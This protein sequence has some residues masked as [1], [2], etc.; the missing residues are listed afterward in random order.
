MFILFYIKYIFVKFYLF[1]LIIFL[2]G[3]IN[4]MAPG[5]PCG[6]TSSGECMNFK[7]YFCLNGEIIKNAKLC[8]CG[9]NQIISGDDCIFVCEDNTLFNE[10]SEKEISYICTNAGLKY[11]P[12]KCGC[13]EHMFFNGTDCDYKTCEDNTKYNECSLS[14]PLFC[15]NGNLI[16]NSNVCG[17]PSNYIKE[18]N[19]CVPVCEDNT[20][21]NECSL[22]KPLF[23]SDG[24]LITK[25]SVCGC[26]EHYTNVND[27]CVLIYEM[28]SKQNTFSY[29]Y[30][31]KT[32][33]ISLVVYKGLNDYLSEQPRVIWYT[34]GESPPTQK[35]FTLKNIDDEIQKPYLDEL[36]NKIKQKNT[37]ENEQALIAIR[38][39][40]NIPYDYTGLYSDTLNS[41][42]AYEVLYSN[43]GVCGEKSELLAYLLRE[44]GFGVVLF[45]FNVENHMAVGIKCYDYDYYDSGYCFIESTAPY[46]VTYSS[47]EYAG[48]GLLT[49]TPEII[50]IS[51][52]RSFDAGEEY[53]D[54]VKYEEINQMGPVLSMRYYNEWLDLVDKYGL[55]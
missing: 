10:C 17:C 49:S 44:L 32:D 55:N 16:N 24:V 40:Q 46:M 15:L 4:F 2:S 27:E 29:T 50:Y 25:A 41:K 54:A 38:L 9:P 13:P 35:D 11:A 45:N 47:G 12:D 51:E 8:G 37:N 21:Y 48:V 33:S 5:E 53:R 36:V 20:K 31:Y 1:L 34:T 18:G 42:Y 6:E 43:K 52:G 7:P 26:P 39:V 22:T 3:C 23:C 30:N 28:D 14:K 19:D